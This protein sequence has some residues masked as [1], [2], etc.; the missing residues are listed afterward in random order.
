MP[1]PQNAFNELIIFYIIIT[2]LRNVI[3]VK[4]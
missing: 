4:F 3:N 2:E 1:S